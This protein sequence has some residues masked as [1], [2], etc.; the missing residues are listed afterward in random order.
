MSFILAFADIRYVHADELTETV[1]Q[2]IHSHYVFIL[3]QL[4]S[5]RNDSKDQRLQKQYKVIYHAAYFKKEGKKQGSRSKFIRK[6][7]TLNVP[8]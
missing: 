2:F 5:L 7:C 3:E 1:Q 8:G 4:F 6:N